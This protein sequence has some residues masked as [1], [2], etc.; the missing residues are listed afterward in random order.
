MEYFGM[1]P[2]EN[3]SDRQSDAY[4]GRFSQKIAKQRCE[5]VRPQEHGNRHAAE[6]A[7]VYQQSRAGLLFAGDPIFDFSAL[8]LDSSGVTVS[9]DGA[10][11][12]IG[13]PPEA[14]IGQ[15]DTALS[16]RVAIRPIS[17]RSGPLWTTA[18]A[19]YIDIV[20]N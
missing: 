18:L 3:Y 2:G 16:L 5:Y 20:E 11:G 14:V 8:P 4:M 6:W 7:A 17:E 10:G 1:G 15:A 12:R 9:I 13:P 19:K